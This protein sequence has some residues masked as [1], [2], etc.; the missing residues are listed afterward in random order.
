MNRDPKC[1]VM[2]LTEAVTWRNELA[3]A[4]KKLVLTNGCFDILHRGHA[5]Y[6]FE[7]RALG[8]A[9]IILINSDAAVRALKGE[10]RPIVPEEHRAY[11]LAALESVDAV[12]VFDSARCNKEMLA[13]RA[14]IYVKGGDYTLDLLDPDERAAL[15]RGK[16]EI[17]FKKFIEGFST[18]NIV[19]RIKRD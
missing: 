11:M 19:E 7:S 17:V 5:E 10:S 4:G 8:D 16:T 6:L 1:K 2:T 18:T 13:L 12:V 15:E 3:C 14:D 9:M